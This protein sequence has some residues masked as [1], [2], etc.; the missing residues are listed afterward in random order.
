MSSLD[1]LLRMRVAHK[2]T[3]SLDVCSLEIVSAD[4]SALPVFEAGAHIDLHLPN[5]LVRPY[6]L[7]NAPGETHRYVIAVLR[8]ATSRGGSAAVHSLLNTGSLLRISKPRNLFALAQQ[9]EHHLLLA[10]GIGITPLL[11]MAQSLHASQA[12]FALHYCSRSP[13][14]TAFVH[15][16]AAAPYAHRVH[17]HFD[18]GPPGQLLDIAAV[19]RNAPPRSHLYVCGPQGFMDM[20]RSA[21]QAAHWDSGR[22]HQESFGAPDAPR[23][24]SAP[25]GDFELE[26]A[27]SGQVIP[28]EANQTALHAL[29]QAGVDVPWSC[30]QGVCGT[31]LTGIVAGQ[32]DHR[33][34]FL[35]PEERDA[36]NQFLP[37]CSRSLSARLVLDL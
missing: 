29:L 11:A 4:G 8:T 16:L 14:R 19:L 10:A 9:A 15:T 35:L 7:C 3:E 30:E 18:N 31:C 23:E 24:G 27:S 2:Q 13:E 32:P 28:V 34:Q 37:C 21:A 33:D 6:S 26:I 12:S 5:G 25:D 22:M 36:N 17:H 20:V 1:D